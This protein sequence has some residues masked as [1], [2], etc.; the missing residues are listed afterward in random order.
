MYCIAQKSV[1]WGNITSST[2]VL[3]ICIMLLFLKLNYNHRLFKASVWRWTKHYDRNINNK[4]NIT[5]PVH[6]HWLKSRGSL[7]GWKRR[8]WDYNL[9]GM[10]HRSCRTR[11]IF[12][13]IIRHIIL[14]ISACFMSS[15]SHNVINLCIFVL[16]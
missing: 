9:Y 7:R 4:L 16:Y 15:A 14:G 12:S 10:N 13:Q 6:T 3:I 1:F 5:D 8:K 2:I 11:L